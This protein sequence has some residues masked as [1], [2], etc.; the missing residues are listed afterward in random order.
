MGTVNP[1]VQ[2]SPLGWVPL[3]VAP[4][5]RIRTWAV[6]C[7]LAL[8]VL[9][10]LVA[11][12]AAVGSLVTV[13]YISFSP[14]SAEA[15]NDLIRVPPERAFAPDGQILLVTVSVSPGRLRAAEYWKAKTID[16]NV[17]LVKQEA[18]YGTSTR[19]DYNKAVQGLMTDSKQAAIFA[20]MKRLNLPVAVR[21]TG[22]VLGGITPG[23]AADGHL[24]AGDVITGIDG[25]P[26]SLVEDVRPL[27]RAH[28]PGDAIVMTVEQEGFATRTVTVNVGSCPAA[29][30]TG[31]TPSCHE[32]DPFLGIGY[33]GTRSLAFDL[34][35]PVTIDSGRIGGPSAGLA[36]TLGLIDQLTPGELTGGQVVAATGE[37][38]ADGTVGPIGEVNLKAV[39][40]TRAGAT[41]FLVPKDAD[42]SEERLA[43]AHVGPGVKVIA[44]GTLD[45]A[46]QAL[47]DVGGDLSGVPAEA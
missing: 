30:A 18:I 34:P 16:S 7:W 40:V 20:A 6:R 29:L 37:I 45:E 25:K 5:S 17:D 11:G 24:F 44:V 35:F 23:S 3:A 43:K 47:K 13:P 42:G 15:V 2:A 22:A 8:A 9:A 10:V 12:V 36:F 21:G 46:L 39:A 32:G 38:R 4:E 27:I 1:S 26:V 31:A 28:R 14:G 41:L 33:E 19:D